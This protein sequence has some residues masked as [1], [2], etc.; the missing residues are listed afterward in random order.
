MDTQI[1]GIFIPFLFLGII[2]FIIIWSIRFYIKRRKMLI[3]FATEH[4]YLFTKYGDINLLNSIYLAIGHSRRMVNVIT[5][6]Y[7]EHPIQFFDFRSV[8]G[9]GKHRRYVNFSV[10]EVEYKSSLRSFLLLSRKMRYSSG[11]LYDGFQNAFGRKIKLEGDFN[12]YFN[13]YVPEDYE[14]EVLQIFTPEIMAKFIDLAPDLTFEFT[15][16]KLFICTNKIISK[17]TDLERLHELA[18]MLI[19]DLASRLV[20]ISK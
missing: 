6:S 18:Q 15:Q 1:T 19:Q 14:I 16:N 20:S 13:L 5:G 17:K 11:N 8:I 12:K 3:A 9:Y 7:L 10:F 4:N 2:I